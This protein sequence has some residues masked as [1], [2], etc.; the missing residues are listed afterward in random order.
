M[1][2]HLA[3]S[4]TLVVGGASGIGRACVD[5]MLS[6]GVNVV[7]WDKSPAASEVAS[8]HEQCESLIVDITN[9]S[10]VE[11]AAEKT[12]QI[13]GPVDHLIHAA[14]IGSGQFGNP[15][16]NLAPSDWTAVVDVNING[17]VHVAHTLAPRM[18]RRNRGTMVFIASVAGQIGSP[19]DPPY[20][21]S[22]AANINFAQVMAKDLASSG[23]RVNTV[24][25]GMVRTPLN[26][27]VWEAWNARQPESAKQSYEEWGNAKVEDLIPLGTWQH[28]EDVAD[29]AVFLSSERAAQVT[30]Q[31]INVD[32]GYVMHS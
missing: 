5:A 15:F 19:T 16:T 8:A 28:P 17:M 6:E 23:I 13:C 27:Q 26:Q 11:Q 21:A 32:G 9:Y 24:C 10:A 31:T 22:K 7:I 29:M 1:E 25:P 18:I 30:G 14:A 2:L 20:S 12:E 4:V 3:G